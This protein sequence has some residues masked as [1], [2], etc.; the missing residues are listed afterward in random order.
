MHDRAVGPTSSLSLC[1]A[2]ATTMEERHSPGGHAG[3]RPH[4]ARSRE[5]RRRRPRPGEPR[6]S[7][8]VTTRY[9]QLSPGRPGVGG[10]GPSSGP[11][12]GRGTTGG[13][14]VAMVQDRVGRRPARSGPW[15]RWAAGEMGAARAALVG[16][17]DAQRAASQRGHPRRGTAPW[18]ASAHDGSKS[19]CPGRS[20]R[21]PAR[22]PVRKMPSQGPAPPIDATGARTVP[23]HV[24]SNL[25]SILVRLSANGA[26]AL[27]YRERRGRCRKL[28]KTGQ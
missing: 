17:R 24:A 25:H 26:T 15:Q 14:R 3:W 18:L 1:K 21:Q 10:P 6:R 7:A 5:V 23:A 12:C 16:G 2:Y 20:A 27:P 8:P 19:G 11:R 13:N 22:S 9:R 28:P 4:S